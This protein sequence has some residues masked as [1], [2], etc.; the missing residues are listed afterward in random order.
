MH[1]REA[2]SSRAVLK[3][4]RR[5]NCAQNRRE[6]DPYIY[7]EKNQKERS[8]TCSSLRVLQEPSGSCVSASKPSSCGGVLLD[9]EDS[10]PQTLAA[11][12]VMLLKTTCQGLKE[13]LAVWSES[14]WFQVGAAQMRH[15]FVACVSFFGCIFH[16]LKPTHPNV[17]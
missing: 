12:F 1:V 13:Q 6:P 5:Q 17:D 14:Q 3:K 4:G 2:L 8:G 15:S 11:I 10:E 9:S 16:Q 7:D